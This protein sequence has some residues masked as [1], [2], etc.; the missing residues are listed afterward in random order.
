MHASILGELQIKIE[1]GSLGT[2]SPLATIKTSTENINDMIVSVAFGFRGLSSKTSPIS[3][4]Q[5]C[6]LKFIQMIY[7]IAYSF[8]EK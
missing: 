2:E 5:P 1:E 8:I 3:S 6:H 7:I 4:P